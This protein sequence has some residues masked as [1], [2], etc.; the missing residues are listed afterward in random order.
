MTKDQLIANLIVERRDVLDDLS[1][2]TLDYMMEDINVEAVWA[3]QHPE[4]V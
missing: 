1:S 3:L 4:A 2:D